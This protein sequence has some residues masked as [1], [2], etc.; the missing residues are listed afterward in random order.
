[1]LKWIHETQIHVLANLL[2]KVYKSGRILQEW[3]IL[4][5]VAIP[6]KTHAKQCGDYCMISLMNRTLKIL[7]K[8]IIHK[9]IYIYKKLEEDIR[10]TQFRLWNGFGTR[11]ALLAFNILAQRCLDGCL[12]FDYNK[13]FDKV[14]H[15]QLV[16][17]IRA[18]QLDK[19]ET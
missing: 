15:D 16:D 5:F 18:N 17:I 13:A 10:E 6:K 8:I 2:N 12:L 7:L 11:E 4:A 19:W 14:R 1:M 3:L 9:S